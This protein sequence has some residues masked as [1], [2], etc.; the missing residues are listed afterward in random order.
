MSANP[1]TSTIAVSLAEL[2]RRTGGR[3]E[4]DPGIL[5]RRVASLTSAGAG[6]ISFLANPRLRA[7]VAASRASAVIL[8]PAGVG[9]T[10]AARLVHEHPYVCFAQVAQILDPHRPP[11]PG[12]HPT[13]S[14]AAG[15]IRN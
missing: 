11:A 3:I 15:A 10:G 5:I 6:D 9:L 12:I 14:V 4:G 13:A 8:A 2:A 7:E 1:A